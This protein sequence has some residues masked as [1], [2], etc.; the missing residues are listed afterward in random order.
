MKL[1]IITT[2]DSQ[3][4]SGFIRMKESVAK[5]GWEIEVIDAPFQFGKQMQVIQKWLNN[6]EGDATHI[7]YIDAFDNICFGSSDE[8]I[9]KFNRFD[10]QMLISAEK[11][12]Y[13]HPERAADYPHTESAWKYVN[14]GGWMGEIN[15]LKD[16][17][18][19]FLEPDSHDQ[20]WLMEMYLKQNQIA[21]DV[22]CEIFQTI[23]FSDPD[24][25][26]KFEECW[27]NKATKTCP[28]FFHGN[29]HTDM[30]WV[31]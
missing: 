9:E 27:V 14:G 20:V 25:W 19:Y 28:I 16:L 4:H 2:C 31:H 26:T 30:S 5:H 11:A 6:Y 8:V 15:Y 29:G 7:I 13:P 1:K 12:C 3:T 10:C 22:N 18:T 21:L 24:E 23:A 17:F